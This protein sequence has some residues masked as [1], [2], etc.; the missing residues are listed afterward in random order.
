MCHIPRP[1]SFSRRSRIT[2][3]KGQL[4]PSSKHHN[5]E[6]KVRE[7]ALSTGRAYY[8]SGLRVLLTWH[9]GFLGQLPHTVPPQYLHN[10]RLFIFYTF[11][12]TF[13]AFQFPSIIHTVFDI[14]AHVFLWGAS[15]KVYLVWQVPTFI[16]SSHSLCLLLILFSCFLCP[17]IPASQYIKVT[18]MLE[19]PF[20]SPFR[21]H[22]PLPI[23][24]YTC[25]YFSYSIPYFLWPCY[26]ILPSVTPYYTNI[27]F[28]V[29][30]FIC[31]L[32]S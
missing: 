10:G 26:Y 18:Y 7:S 28:F 12:T 27:I 25:P 20:N 32:F 31:N 4:K 15:R 22:V 17:R 16:H 1:S 30:P 13:P 23:D 8:I 21:V 24:T 2:F 19:S 9:P 5:S 6:N 29:V 11:Y 3:Y 14:E